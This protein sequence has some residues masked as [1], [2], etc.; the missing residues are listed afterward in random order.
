MTRQR[1]W[2]GLHFTLP[3]DCEDIVSG[4]RHLLIEKDFLPVMEIRW[5]LPAEKKQTAT[6]DSVV[7][8]FKKSTSN[9]C[10]EVPPPRHLA[11]FAKENAICCLQTDN[12]NEGISLIWQYRKCRTLILCRIYTHPA[13]FNDDIS[14]T[15]QSISCHHQSDQPTLWSVQDFQ[16]QIPAI[17][18]LAGYSFQAGLT[19]LLFE[20]KAT[21]LLFCRMAPASDRLAD[22]SL[23]ELLFSLDDRLSKDNIEENN[24]Q[25]AS[26]GTSPSLMGQ[27]LLRLKRKKAFCQGIIR[28]D[29]SMN[30]ILAIICES[31]HPIEPDSIQS[32]FS[33]YEII[34]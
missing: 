25:T 15:L 28:H 4:E 7:R 26:A 8:Q 24:A 2:N 29:H 11:K 19:R 18:R 13:V 27:I 34:S 30:R 14:K 1:G 3:E 17:Y 20:D 21:R 22:K 12:A 6:I 5:E 32:L 10:R 33:H 16:L 31:N 9:E 23:D